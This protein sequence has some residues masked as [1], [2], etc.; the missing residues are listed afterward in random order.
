MFGFSWIEWKKN[1]AIYGFCRG[2]TGVAEDLAL[3]YA[4]L[5]EDTTFH[6]LIIQISPKKFRELFE[7]VFFFYVNVTRPEAFDLRNQIPFFT[8]LGIEDTFRH[9]RSIKSRC[10]SV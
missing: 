9:T 7:V 4:K 1:A 3:R 6:K 5:R 8:F 2:S 10:E